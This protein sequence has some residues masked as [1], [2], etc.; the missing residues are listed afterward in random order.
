MSD[1]SAPGGSLPDAPLVTVII[2]TKN[3]PELLARA[4]QSVVAQVY[5]PI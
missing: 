5:R 4:L 2:R 1:Q 3:R